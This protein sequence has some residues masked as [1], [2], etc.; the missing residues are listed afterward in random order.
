MQQF[1]N[2]STALASAFMRDIVDGSV[3]GT[4]NDAVL[5]YNVA[6]DVVVGEGL[7][8]VHD[9]VN[10]D[11][12]DIT[13]SGVY[14]V[15]QVFSQAASVTVALGLS[16]DVAAAGLT[17][18]PTMLLAGMLTVG[19]AIL[20]AANSMHHSLQS[21]IQVT[22]AQAE[23]SIANPNGHRIRAHGTNGAGAVVADAAVLTNTDCFFR[24]VRLGD[25]IQ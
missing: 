20:P 1:L 12:I 5:R 9:A 7:T 18:D 8:I 16:A 6:N 11:E 2:Q 14:L 22:A 23:A 21:I 24:V 10:G 3:G 4:T 15:Q 13:R 17:G 25:V 19:G